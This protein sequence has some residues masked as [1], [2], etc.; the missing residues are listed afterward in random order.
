MITL[1]AAVVL[2]ACGCVGLGVLGGFVDGMTSSGEPYDEPYVYGPDEPD[3]PTTAAPVTPATTPSG[4]P[5]RYTV[6]YE[7]TG[8]DDV[9]VQFYDADGDFHQLDAVA[10]PW[11]LRFTANDR[12]KVQIVVGATESDGGASCRITI[13]GKVVSRNSGG[14]GVACFGW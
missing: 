14:W 6:V 12:Q 2:A 11:R 13:N 7:V 3:E 5:G 10:A 9:S 1:V 8:T 4:G